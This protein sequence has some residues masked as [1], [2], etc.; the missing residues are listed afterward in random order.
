MGEVAKFRL[1]DVSEDLNDPK[2][3]KGRIAAGIR[4]G[5]R[6]EKEAQAVALAKRE[7]E[8][9]GILSGIK[10][11]HIDELNRSGRIVSRAAHR[12]GLLQGIV[13]GMIA[14][15]CVGLATWTVLREVVI[16]NVNVAR[17][18]IASVPVL[19]D[20]GNSPVTYERNPREPDDAH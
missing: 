12:D 6:R 15:I 16:T 1:A 20:E 17:T 9:T 8:V 7:G 10:N 14:A 3:D 18:P 19:R 2:T 11:A 5:R 4:E 13:L